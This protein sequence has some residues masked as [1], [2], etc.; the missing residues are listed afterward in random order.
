[1]ENETNTSA[2]SQQTTATETAKPSSATIPPPAVHWGWINEVYWPVLLLWDEAMKD[3]LGASKR[4]GELPNE[5]LHTLM[6]N[7]VL[8][9]ED[10]VVMLFHSETL[11]KTQYLKPFNG[12]ASSSPSPLDPTNEYYE[13]WTDAVEL[14]KDALLHP[15]FYAMNG[16]DEFGPDHQTLRERESKAARS[17]SKLVQGAK[18]RQKVVVGSNKRGGT[19]SSSSTTSGE[20]GG[21]LPAVTIPKKKE[22]AREKIKAFLTSLPDSMLLPSVVEERRRRH[23]RH[24]ERIRR[25]AHK[26][27]ISIEQ[28]REEEVQRVEAEKKRKEREAELDRVRKLLE[29]ESPEQRFLRL[30]TLLAESLE[31]GDLARALKMVGKFFDMGVTKELLLAHPDVVKHLS[32]LRNHADE[33]VAGKAKA[34]RAKWKGV[35]EGTVVLASSSVPVGE[36]VV[37]PAPQKKP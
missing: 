3:S 23:E 8:Q 26:R 7:D 22:R 20:D 14:A 32:D 28:A 9:P 31:Q 4:P 34:L 29:N 2:L 24:E 35:F 33:E 16:A 13:E 5:A 15:Q 25:I 36:A 27:N 10:K 30:H 19:F 21:G 12:E 6:I 11:A 17:Q 37:A 1:M 18:K